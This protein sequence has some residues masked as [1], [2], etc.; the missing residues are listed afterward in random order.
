MKL[1]VLPPKTLDYPDPLIDGMD[2]YNIIGEPHLKLKYK[3]K[4]EIHTSDCS[5]E[6]LNI[7]DVKLMVFKEMK[8]QGEKKRI[9]AKLR[10][11]ERRE[12]FAGSIGFEDYPDLK[13]LNRR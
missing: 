4:E 12:N 5:S 7:Q 6:D 11:M 13:G 8:N 3:G 10:A 9:K 2:F 1:R